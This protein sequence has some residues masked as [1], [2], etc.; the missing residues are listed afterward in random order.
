MHKKLE[1]IKYYISF[2]TVLILLFICH[3]NVLAACLETNMFE[4]DPGQT[5][6]CDD[7]DWL[8]RRNGAGGGTGAIPLNN[9]LTGNHDEPSVSDLN[10]MIG[11]AL[12]YIV[13]IVGSMALLMF[14]YGGFLW[15][16]ASGSSEKIQA[17]KNVLVWATI[18]I[19][20]IFASYGLVK[21]V[22]EILKSGGS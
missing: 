3:N 20:V 7:E 1:K 12:N 8:C 17:G 6:I 16:T 14:I 15:M 18:G 9:P 22:L 2:S 11:G 4:C 21:A 10:V 5:L 13:G 19:F